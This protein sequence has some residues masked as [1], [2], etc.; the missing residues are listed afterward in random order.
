MKPL[1][2]LFDRALAAHQADDLVTARDIYLEILAQ[3]PQHA[4]TL[5]MLGLLA[6]QLGQF[7][8]AIIWF[9]Q[10]LRFQTADPII[11]NNM[12][13]AFKQL[14]D[15]ESAQQHY[16]Q[17]IALDETYSDAYNNL[18]GLFYKQELLAEAEQN[19]LKAIA[20]QPDYIEA[21]I[22][23]GLLSIKKNNLAEAVAQFEQVLQ[24]QP[25]N[26]IAL[27]QLA[28]LYLQQEKL[29]QAIQHYQTFLGFQPRHV[30]ALNNVGV[31]YLKQQDA[32]S[33]IEYLNKALQV[34]P[35]HQDARSNLAGTLLQ[36]DRFTEA[37]WHYQ[38]YL[39][40]AP[41]DYQAHYSLGAAYMAAGYFQEA[42]QQFKKILAIKSDHTDSY[43]N[44][45][46]IYLKMGKQQLAIEHYQQALTLQPDNQAI[47]Y[48][49]N[50]LTGKVNPEAAPADYVKN[51]FDSYAGHFDQELIENLHY[52]VPILLRQSLID[53]I[54]ANTKWRVLDLGCGSGL[55]GQELKDI[56]SHLTGV[57]ISP[58]MLS[59]AK[60]KNIYDE[61][62][63]KDIISALASMD[64]TYDLII[65]ADTLVYFGDLT[66]V[67]AGVYAVLRMQGLFAFT[68]ETGDV[69]SYQLSSTARYSHARTYVEVLAKHFDLAILVDKKITGRLQQGEPV[70]GNLFVLRK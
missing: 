44:L 37:I 53:Y 2:E 3:Q 54:S 22:N 26:N 9:K 23:L 50:A 11:H 27:W 67:F 51:L 28:N 8:N 21:R 64:A 16:Q 65:A 10:A 32:A 17:A 1:D 19:F 68:I 43:C 62:I 48:M 41:E 49:L 5:H 29:A 69:P 39:Q 15:W 47:E 20:L 35:K 61:L 13:N 57:D 40:L 56:A 4:Q 24:L 46:A 7:E 31:L 55:S 14:K 18:G 36:Q 59:K 58:R 42:I 30:E 63:E 66:P 33:A 12:G 38:L 70:E 60:G 52:Q 6:A 25:Q 45:G 34:E